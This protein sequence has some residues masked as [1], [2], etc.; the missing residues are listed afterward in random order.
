[1]TGMRAY[2]L[3]RAAVSIA[4]GVLFVLTGASWWAGLLVAIVAF[5]WFL[6]APHTGRYAVHPELGVT[7]LRRDERSQGIND[8]A[9]R[10][11]FVVSMVALAGLVLYSGATAAA[12]VSLRAL[13]GLLVLGAAVYYVSDFWLRKA[14][15]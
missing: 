8:K 10:N 3:S 9:A 6:V 15:S 4:F 12:G 14:S 1:M 11:A 7:A 5:G 2:Y 13:E